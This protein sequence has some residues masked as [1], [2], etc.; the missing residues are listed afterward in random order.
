MKQQ[1]KVIKSKDPLMKEIEVPKGNTISPVREMRERLESLTDRLA[2]DKFHYINYYVPGAE[3][4]FEGRELEKFRRVGKHYP[5]AKGG[6][7]YIDEPR[8]QSEKDIC[9]KKAEVMKTL[10]LRYIIVDRDFTEDE[11]IGMHS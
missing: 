3:R 11:I 5:H 10:G 4:F 9:A 8:F 6:P 7:L 2:Q 1:A